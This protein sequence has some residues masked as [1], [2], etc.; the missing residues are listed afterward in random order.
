MLTADRLVQVTAGVIV[1]DGTVL[2]CQRP[3]GGHHP[4]KWEFPGGKVE[5]GES[6][7]AGMRRELQEELG[8]DA[9]VGPVL[10]RTQHQYPGRDPFVLTF[11]AI[12]SYTGTLT[13]RCFA[14]IRWVAVT[15]LDQ[16]NFL[17][18]DREFVAQLRSGRVRLG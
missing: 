15:A 8:I 18:G 7:E 10:W 17:E 6:L 1:H 5:S 14:A 3:P 4:G 13:N 11:F 9:V 16:V 12:P 2:V